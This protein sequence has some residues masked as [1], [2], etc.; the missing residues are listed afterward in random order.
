M[1]CWTHG[2][3]RYPGAMSSRDVDDRCRCP[4]GGTSNPCQRRA[5]QE[6]IRCDICGGRV[7]APEPAQL[8]SLELRA[9]Q[10][11]VREFWPEPD[12]PFTFDAGDIV[13]LTE[14]GPDITLPGWPPATPGSGA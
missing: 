7:Y 9:P 14:P 3:T 11:G 8:N 2:N 4:C 12:P 5:T 1:C 13:Q 10:P 6:D